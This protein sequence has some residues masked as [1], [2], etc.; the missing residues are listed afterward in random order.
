MFTVQEIADNEKEAFFLLRP[1]D[2]LCKLIETHEL[3]CLGGG[4]VNIFCGTS[5]VRGSF[6]VRVT[7]CKYIVVRH[8]RT[9]DNI[10]S[11]HV[12]FFCL[13]GAGPVGGTR[14]SESR[15]AMNPL[16]FWNCCFARESASAK[17]T[18]HDTSVV[19]RPWADPGSGGQLKP[20]PGQQCDTRPGPGVGGIP[21]TCSLLKVTEAV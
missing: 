3:F 8:R 6:S 14:F 18:T 15:R 11:F 20:G 17:P 4:T 5:Y 13:S 19:Q 21:G 9:D 16:N 12:F 7:E 2:Q 10:H 1:S